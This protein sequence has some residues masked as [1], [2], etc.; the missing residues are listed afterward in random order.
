MRETGG[1]KLLDHPVEWNDTFDRER[2][3]DQLMPPVT[4]I[5]FENDGDKGDTYT[6]SCFKK[7]S[8]RGRA[9]I[10]YKWSLHRNGQPN[11]IMAPTCTDFYNL[12]RDAITPGEHYLRSATSLRF[13]G[14]ERH[15]DPFVSSFVMLL[16]VSCVVFFFYIR[17]IY[18]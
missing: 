8:S 6:R 9:Y 13:V 18:K 12:C 11:N 10:F 3:F 14:H 1:K 16:R 17:A 15:L 2:H 4:W 5:L 7:R